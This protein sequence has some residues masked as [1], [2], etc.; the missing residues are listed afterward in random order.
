MKL[1]E[2]RDFRAEVVITERRVLDLLLQQPGVEPK[3]IAYIGH[4][5]GGIAG[6]VLAGI[7]PRI[8]AFVLIGALP[9]FAEHMEKDQ[10]SYWQ[11]MRKSMSSADFARTMELIRETDPDHFL[12][13]ARAPIL[14][15]CARYDTGRNV[16]GCLEVHRLAG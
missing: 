9:S 6:G 3:R 4:S 10:A 15:Q 12:P 2:A 14:V 1:E 7:E 11:D 16:R 5:Y 13:A 8:A